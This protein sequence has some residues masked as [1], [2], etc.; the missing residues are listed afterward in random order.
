MK[1]EE[2]ISK[3]LDNNLNHQELEAFKKLEDYDDLVTLNHRLRAFKNDEYNTS[4]E[5]ER[6]LSKIKSKKT[7]SKLWMKPLLRIAA[8]L[9]ICCA[10]YYYTTTLD[11]TIQTEFAQKTTIELPD[12][13]TVSLNAKTFLAYNKKSWKNKRTIELNGEA[14]FKVAK[15]STF[16]VITKAGNVTVYGTQFNV[17]QRDHYFEVI[18]YEGV[19]GV[20]F[21]STLSKLKAGDSFLIIDGKLIAKEKE[22]TLAPS[23]L[24][25]ESHFKSM[26]YKEVLAEFER[27]YNIVIISENI[28]KNQL[29]TGSFTHNNMDLALKSMT[30]PLHITYS[31]NNHTIILKRD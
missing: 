3:W 27:Q 11:T 1:R 17:K 23:W 24:Q 4:K 22:E 5:L 6:V 25:N 8:I 31:K 2:L 18:C 26:P 19:V 15:G 14:F 9:A 12:A 20:T 10:L 28:D 29:F 16:N 21:N 13:S 30:L 7:A